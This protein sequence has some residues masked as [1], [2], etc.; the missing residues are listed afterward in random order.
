MLLNYSILL[1][2]I[3]RTKLEVDQEWFFKSI[4]CLVIFWELFGV[5]PSYIVFQI[6]ES[7]KIV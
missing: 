4:C 6:E 1:N 5:F 2:I 7:F 3:F